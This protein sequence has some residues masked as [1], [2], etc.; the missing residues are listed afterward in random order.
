MR[1]RPGSY[2][3][4]SHFT[5]DG[6]PERMAQAVEVFKKTQ[7]PA[8]PRSHAQVMR[9]FDGFE[10]V[11]PGLVY[12]SQWRPES[13]EDPGDQPHHSNLYAAVGRKL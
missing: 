8:Y 10:L 13:A 5:P 12:T 1:I 4:M 2:L 9:L 3:A 11:A 7:E 6:M